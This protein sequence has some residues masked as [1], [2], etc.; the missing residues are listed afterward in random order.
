MFDVSLITWKLFGSVQLIS[1]LR[2]SFGRLL[3]LL[4]LFLLFLLLR[5]FRC[6]LWSV[7]QV[8]DFVVKL[9]KI[10]LQEH[11]RYSRSLLRLILDWLFLGR[12]FLGLLFLSLFSLDI[13]LPFFLSDHTVINILKD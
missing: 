10:V 8:L 11:I 7:N 5:F 9:I 2:L 6:L 1:L 12:F 13:F 3:W 4:S